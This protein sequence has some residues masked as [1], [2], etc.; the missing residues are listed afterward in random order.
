M[1]NESKITSNGENN[2]LG[3]VKPQKISSTIECGCFSRRISSRSVSTN[4]DTHMYKSSEIKKEKRKT[5]VSSSV[6]GIMEP[7]ASKRVP[8]PPKNQPDDLN[9]EAISDP[10]ETSLTSSGYGTDEGEVTGRFSN[11]KNAGTCR[12]AQPLLSFEILNKNKHF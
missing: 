5:Y 12:Q 9:C 4:T 2:K 8:F 1:N 3:D 6:K 7:Y 10:I 11:R